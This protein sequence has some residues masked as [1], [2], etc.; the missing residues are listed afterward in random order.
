MAAAGYPSEKAINMEQKQI[1]KNILQLIPP[2]RYTNALVKLFFDECNDNYCLLDRDDFYKQYEDWWVVQRSNPV[3]MDLDFLK[4]LLRVL[5]ISLQ[6]ASPQE[7][8]FL[9]DLKESIP[10]TSEKF[11]R[12]ALSLSTETPPSSITHCQEQLLEASWYKHEGLVRE[13]WFSLGKAI[14]CAQELGM[15]REKLCTDEVDQKYIQACKILW[16]TLYSWDRAMSIMLGRPL[17]IEDKYCNTSLPTIPVSRDMRILHESRGIFTHPMQVRIKEIE[18]SIFSTKICELLYEPVDLEKF[19]NLEWDLEVFVKSFKGIPLS[20]E[21]LESEACLNEHSIQMHA[22]IYFTSRISLLWCSIYKLV[23]FKSSDI[24][25]YQ[26]YYSY[27]AK[28]LQKYSC[29]LIRVNICTFRRLKPQC[30]KNFGCVLYIFEP[31]LLLCILL[32]RRP[33][34]CDWQEAENTVKEGLHV[35]ETLRHHGRLASISFAIIYELLAKVKQLAME[36]PYS[37]V[38]SNDSSIDLRRLEQQTP[39]MSGD[40]SLATPNSSTAMFDYGSSFLN[41]ETSKF[42]STLDLL[43]SDKTDDDSISQFLNLGW[44]SNI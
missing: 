9:S 43:Y 4:L 41:E 40:S 24:P 10:E 13:S 3:K 31:C 12:V 32:F 36:S 27:A 37:T 34:D 8:G 35:L 21:Q 26:N 17:G 29:D 18:I 6:F 33:D 22:E 1:V 2:E 15:H 25:E 14:R 23:A 39:N 19:Q 38:S 16:W 5:A 30:Y 42:L 7:E 11:H 44:V 20:K 28:K